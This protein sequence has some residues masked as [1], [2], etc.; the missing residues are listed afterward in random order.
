MCCTVQ[1]LVIL[2]KKIIKSNR[3]SNPTCYELVLKG[4]NQTGLNQYNL[5]QSSPSIVPIL[6]VK[7]M[8]VFKIKAYP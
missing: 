7:I 8:K 1:Y 6:I 2:I 4:V 5:I 3:D